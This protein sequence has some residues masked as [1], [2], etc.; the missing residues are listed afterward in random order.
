MASKQTKAINTIKGLALDMISN[1]GSGH[2]GIALGSTPIIYALYTNCLNV[3]PS[4]PN[5]MNRDRFV[6]SC[7]HGSAMYYAMLHMAGY[8]ISIDDL[9]RFRDIDSFTPGHPECDPSIGIDCSTGALG[10]G[11][12][13]AVG[14]ALGER[15]LESICKSYDKKSNLVNFYTYVMCS[16]GDLQEG[17]S[18]EA[19]AFAGAQ[20]LNKLIVLYDSNNVQLDGN[21]NL[22]S[23][24][25]V[26]ARFESIGFNIIDV[27]NG[28][29]VN[30]I[31]DA[32]D[33]AKD[34]KKPSII[35]CHTK[36]GKDSSFE[37]TNAAHGK[38]FDN[39]EVE[40][41][42]R[43][44]ELPFEPFAYLEEIRDY[45]T[46]EIN[47][48][49]SKYYESW[50]KTYD[51]AL[52]SRIKDVV[53]IINLLERNEFIIDFDSDNYKINE[54]YF[55]SGRNSNNKAMNFVASKTKFFL[56]GN[57]DLSSSTKAVIERSGI[58]N[59]V[60]PMDRNI[61]F[62]VRE[63][64][65]GAIL[66]GMA[67]LNLRVYGG[68]Y[69]VFADYLKPAL[70]MSA[71]MN[72]PVTYIF[73]HDSVAIGQ[74]GA[75]HEPIEQLTMLRSTPNLVTIRPADIKETIGAWEY[76][77][78]N[79]GPVALVLSK[80]DNHAL[81]HTRGK[82]VKYGAYIVKKEKEK[83]NLILLATGSEVETA[84]KLAGDLETA[85]IGVR[86]VSMPSME[87]FLKQKSTYEDQLLPKNVLTVTLEAGSTLLWHRFATDRDCALGIDTFGVSGKS[88]DVL[89]FVGFDYNSLLI[90]IKQIV[91]SH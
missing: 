41:I 21:T 26:E 37:G 20:K 59:D 32:I 80:N 86:V 66:N 54:N 81:V 29:S 76:I 73:T 65:M 13:N 64:A 42:K 23:N 47:K 74:D 6:L 34:S 70:R 25:D 67:L 91:D 12:A 38:A 14:I 33:E 55:D 28:N 19:L 31:S 49:V 53:N 63:H 45:V 85:G 83:L 58:L 22:T 46:S 61:F 8:D 43:K 36:L 79:P 10:Q 87:L 78:K 82:Y 39:T 62:G 18:Y 69:L 60:T 40:S 48:R 77:V 1:A 44:L 30:A 16:D 89:K 15:Y 75:T 5:W 68:T 11:V 51:K 7:G 24:E 88:E 4:K 52:E 56:G 71:L 17:I 2:P 90:K 27:K 35:I 9:K 50:Q 57:A 72:L 3:M 84:I